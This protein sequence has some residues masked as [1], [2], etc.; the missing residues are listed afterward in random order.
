MRI[1]TLIALAAAA[2][3]SN[4]AMAAIVT[5]QDGFAGYAGTL[6]TAVF[7]QGVNANTAFASQDTPVNT[8]LVD[9]TTNRYG[10][11]NLNGIAQVLLR[12]DDI[13]GA[14][15]IPAGATINSATLQVR[16]IDSTNNTVSLHRM[17]ADWSGATTWNSLVN[18]V[19]LGS[20]ALAVADA[21]RTV[22]G[23]G[24]TTFDVT[25]SLQAWA[26]GADNLGWAFLISGGNSWAFRND[27]HATLAHRP[28]LTVDFTPA[29]APVSLPGS[30]YMMGGAIGMFAVS[31]R[32]LRRGP[33]RPSREG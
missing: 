33:Q 31:R 23:N 26:G 16:T 19:T 1:R 7:S 12:F 25:T 8:L 32:D 21:S 29:P 28:L 18:G 11:G 14:L 15:G 20:D 3:G 27:N 24:F 17:Q 5:F 10:P 6:S 4:P 2:V 22:I 9:Q 30:L 13:F